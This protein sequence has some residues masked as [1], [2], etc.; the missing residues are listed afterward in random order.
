MKPEIA[1]GKTRC[2]SV[3]P[4][5]PGLPWSA[6]ENVVYRHW[7]FCIAMLLLSPF[8]AR[9]ASAQVVPAVRLPSHISVFTTFTDAKPD[10][11]Y[12]GDL[13]VYGISAGVIAQTP[14]IVGAEVRGAILRSGGIEHQE[15]ILAG[16]RAALH[17]KRISPYVSVLAG[18][19]NA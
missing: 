18:A 14:H 11:R 19:G 1:A 3:E 12:Y 15:S 5:Q 13:A 6:A 8:A 16:P 7:L 9:R 10:F 17:F 2:E 4:R